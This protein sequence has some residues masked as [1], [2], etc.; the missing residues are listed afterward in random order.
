MQGRQLTRCEGDSVEVERADRLPNW[1]S[2]VSRCCAREAGAG[3]FQTDAGKRSSTLVGL[4]LAVGKWAAS[5][6]LPAAASEPAGAAEVP[7][8]PAGR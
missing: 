8:K 3:S 5:S 4:L 7:P 6:A 1:G 2:A